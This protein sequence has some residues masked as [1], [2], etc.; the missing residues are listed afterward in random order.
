VFG[1]DKKVASACMLR[2]GCQK[3]CQFTHFRALPVKDRTYVHPQK[4]CSEIAE[5]EGL[6]P[7]SPFGQ[8]FSSPLTASSPNIRNLPGNPLLTGQGR[9]ATSLLFRLNPSVSVPL[10]ACRRPVR[11]RPGVPPRLLFF[12]R[13][14]FS[15]SSGPA[16]VE[17]EIVLIGTRRYPLSE[18]APRE[19]PFLSHPSSRKPACLGLA[20]HRK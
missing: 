17:L 12:V 9:G 11:T 19:P 20:L 10:T 15:I 4:W 13:P 7:P 8:R 18:H 1:P 16:I 6:E 5:G 3:G 14:A 2:A